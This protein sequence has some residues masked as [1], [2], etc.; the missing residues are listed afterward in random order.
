MNYVDQT[1]NAQSND[2]Q[3]LRTDVEDLK[4]DN[5][6]LQQE[7]QNLKRDYERLQQVTRIH[8]SRMRTVHCSGHLSCHAHMHTTV[9]DGKYTNQLSP[10]ITFIEI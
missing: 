10:T 4:R 7:N 9:T 6:D 1:N 3:Q 2:I 5:N 8:S